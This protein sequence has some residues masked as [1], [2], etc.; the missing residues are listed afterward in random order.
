MT[1]KTRKIPHAKLRIQLPG[2]DT[3]KPI[4]RNGPEPSPVTRKKRFFAHDMKGCDLIANDRKIN[5]CPHMIE[6]A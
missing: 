5:Y 1:G 6:R 2:K 3:K 4:N